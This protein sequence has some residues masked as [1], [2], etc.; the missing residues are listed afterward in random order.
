MNLC[1]GK[2]QTALRAVVSK[3]VDLLIVRCNG[4]CHEKCGVLV[5]T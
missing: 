5:L 4:C 3:L 2:E 1:V